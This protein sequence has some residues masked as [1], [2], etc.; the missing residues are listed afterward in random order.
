M[1]NSRRLAWHGLLKQVQTRQT[2][3]PGNRC[4]GQPSAAAPTGVPT[5]FCSSGGRTQAGCVNAAGSTMRLKQPAAQCQARCS[6]TNWVAGWWARL[7]RRRLPLVLPAATVH[8]CAHA[9]AGQVHE[10]LHGPQLHS[11]AYMLLSAQNSCG[12]LPPLAWPRMPS[13][14][15]EAAAP[16]PLAAAQI[17]LC[18]AHTS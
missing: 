12:I 3:K 4:P 17:V 2:H 8:P 10:M 1:L 14:L 15:Q 11:S 9:H 13:L 7:G 5:G 18:P 6:S 16:S